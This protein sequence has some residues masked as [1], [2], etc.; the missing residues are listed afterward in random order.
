MA[1]HSDHISGDEMHEH[2]QNPSPNLSLDDLSDD[3]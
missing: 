1:G 3:D 2:E